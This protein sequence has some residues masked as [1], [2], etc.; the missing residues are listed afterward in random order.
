MEELIR[1]NFYFKNFF[2][3][4][5]T[6]KAIMII[7]IIGFTVFSNSLFNSFV[8]DDAGQIVNNSSIHS[9]TSIL[10]TFL[11]RSGS[12]EINPFYRP[13]PSIF[14]TLIYSFSGENTFLY[15]LVQLVFHIGNTI[16]IFL[17]FKK[18]LRRKTS[19]LL[20][21]LFLVHPINEET[22]VYI[23]NLQDVLFV[24]FGLLSFYILQRNSGRNINIIFASI[25][26]LLSL[27]SKET[28][29]LFL[30][31]DV[32]YVYLFKREKC[33]FFF[34]SSLFSGAFYF[35]LRL[36]ISS[37]IPKT[38]SAPITSL[39]LWDRM[40]NMPAIIFYYF[41]NLFFPWD[42]VSINKWIISKIN[43]S[44][45]YLPVI[46]DSM[47]FLML[48]SICFYLYK[49][50]KL[51]GIFY[52]LWFMMG[53][54]IHLQIIPLDATVANRWFYFPF[55][56][57]LG[58]IGLFFQTIHINKR[59]LKAYMALFSLLLPILMLRT[60][61]R[62]TDWQNQSTLLSHD[63][64]LSKNDY[65]LELLYG[66]DFIDKGKYDEA[67]PHIKKALTIFPKGYSAWNSLG[68]IYHKKGDLTQ[69]KK[70][71]EK[72]IE[73]GDYYGAYEN[74]G[75]LLFKTDKSTSTLDFLRKATKK[76][77][78]SE[79]LWYQRL[80]IEYSLGNHDDALVAAQNYYLLK[81]DAESYG[82]YNHLRQKLPL[83]IQW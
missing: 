19:L 9:L 50:K 28:G 35:F 74:L 43:F 31:I 33:K 76:F 63:I 56:G 20:S 23:S 79:K 18:F 80:L 25:F 11:N 5:T 30:I 46:L 64:K 67:Y 2:V 6:A 1:T 83:N 45:F 72:S 57:F 82:I 41:R 14:F 62:N 81:K 21:L 24:F 55:I 65:Q 75:Q 37:S 39:N 52:L 51:L 13:L 26:L 12:L 54:G 66:N 53:L 15:H 8:F 3:P 69:A 47:I 78:Y 7:I 32:V 44:N 68:I 49:K 40:L 58:L 71:Y 17:I 73:I 36:I 16:L 22:V 4:L 60:I 34:L 10:D 38:T 59:L 48:S 27:L 29:S 70:A 42:L 61:I 77:S